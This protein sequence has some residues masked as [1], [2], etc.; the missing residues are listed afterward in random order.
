MDYEKLFP[1]KFLKSADFGGRDV[2]LT[3]IEIHAEDI[4]DKPKAIMSFEGTKKLMVLNRTNAEALK[5][6]FGRETEKWVGKRITFFPATIKDPFSDE[7]IT[8]IRVRG[9]PDITKN[10]SATIQRGRK[11]LKVSVIPTGKQQQ[12]TLPQQNGKAVT[13][14]AVVDVGPDET[15]ESALARVNGEPPPDMILPGQGESSPFVE[16]Q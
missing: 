3:I 5:L 2:T 16:G 4:D 7:M 11:Q 15:E 12:A 13:R 1:G 10:A 8:A 14:Q 6:M 9:S